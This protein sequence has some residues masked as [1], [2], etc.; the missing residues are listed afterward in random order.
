MF[1]YL[2]MPKV[3]KYQEF[4]ERPCLSIF[5]CLFWAPIIF[6]TLCVRACCEHSEP[7][8]SELIY[9]DQGTLMNLCLQRFL[10]VAIEDSYRRTP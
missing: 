2:L 7:E 4:S 10:L 6:I 5:S 1:T 9:Y 3:N 8:I